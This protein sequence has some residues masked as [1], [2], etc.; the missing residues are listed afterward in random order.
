VVKIKQYEI[1]FKTVGTMYSAYV[2]AFHT[3]FK[4]LPFNQILANGQQVHA[5]A[6]SSGNGLEFEVAV[7]PFRFF[8]LSFSGDWQ[9]STY[10]DFPAG[11]SAGT[12]G[13]RVQRQP[14]FQARVTPSY[15][16]P[17]DWGSVKLHATWTTIGDRWSDTQNLQLLPGYRTL[18]AGVLV[19]IG[20]KVE[21]RLSGN[22][23]T[24]AFGLTEGNARIIGNG[25]GNVVF[26]R[27]IFGR[28]YE[29]SL[30]YRF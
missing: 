1:G 13:N 23:L 5:V 4:G 27:P 28:N 7:R 19:A 8:Q 18:D 22:N 9:D 3:D 14:K 16:I 17:T 6:G 20:D 21:L 30:L 2:T 12:N 25:T 26:G 24:N 11:S 29:A 15:R 10:K